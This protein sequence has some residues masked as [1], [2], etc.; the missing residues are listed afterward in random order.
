MINSRT[1]IHTMDYVCVY[2]LYVRIRQH[3]VEVITQV[4]CANVKAISRPP[5]VGIMKI[6]FAVCLR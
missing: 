5:C 3:R 4:M 6:Y 2:A 1:D